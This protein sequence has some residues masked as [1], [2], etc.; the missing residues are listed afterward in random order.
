[1]NYNLLTSHFDRADSLGIPFVFY[2]YKGMPL[3][4]RVDRNKF[5]CFRCWAFLAHITLTSITEDIV[6]DRL[7]DYREMHFV[8]YNWNINFIQT[9]V[10]KA[11]YFR[12]YVIVRYDNREFR[13]KQ[14]RET[15]YIKTAS[16]RL[17]LTD[18]SFIKFSHYEEMPV[19]RRRVQNY[20]RHY[21]QDF[22]LKNEEDVQ[23]LVLR[24]K[25]CDPN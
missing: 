8:G 14:H 3:I 22:P 21:Q 19:W 10:E 9:M 15:L 1:M 16:Q 24:D 4:G 6:F 2:M 25:D 12:R 7:T 17:A 11:A 13:I 5:L 20:N 18:N 23:R